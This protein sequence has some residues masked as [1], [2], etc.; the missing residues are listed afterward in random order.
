MVLAL[1]ELPRPPIRE[2]KHV[3]VKLNNDVQQNMP[4]ARGLSLNIEEVGGDGKRECCEEGSERLP[5]GRGRIVLDLEESQG[6]SK[7]QNRMSENTYVCLEVGLL[8]DRMNVRVNLKNVGNR[9]MRLN[10]VTDTTKQG[11]EFTAV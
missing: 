8:W 6:R 7:D 2:D 4:R 1:K 10:V 5:G 3:R 9:W 11:S